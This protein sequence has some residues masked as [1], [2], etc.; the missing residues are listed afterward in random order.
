M[1]SAANVLE[2]IRYK[3]YSEAFKTATLLD[4]LMPVEING[5]TKTRY[6]HWTDKGNPAFAKYLHTWGEAGTEVKDRSVQCMFGGYALEHQGDTYRMWNPQT[7]GIHETRDI[8]WSHQMYYSK[9]SKP[10]EETAPIRFSV[11]NEDDN[12]PESIPIQKAEKGEIIES[13]PYQG[14][15]ESDSNEV[16]DN[17][18]ESEDDEPNVITT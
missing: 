17:K 18:S 10:G 4:S 13:E 16:E 14:V 12:G 7:G 15:Y 5:V 1:M 2:T 6:K 11:I 9:P 8:I 3:V